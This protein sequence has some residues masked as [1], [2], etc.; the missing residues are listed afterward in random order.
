MTSSTAGSTTGAQRGRA[1]PGD[2]P[3]R[4]VGARPVLGLVVLGLVALGL[5]VLGTGVVPT[6]HAQATGGD[7]YRIGDAQP[8]DSVNPFNEQNEISF[9]ITSLTYDLLLNYGTDDAQPDLAHSLARSYHVSKDGKTWRFILR[10]GVTWSDGKPFTSADVKWT[11]DAVR[12]NTTNV[13][14]AYLANVSSVRAPTTTSVVLKLSSPDVRISSIFVPILPKHVFAK[15]PVKKLDSISLPLPSVTTAPF[16][17]TSYDKTGTTILTRNPRFRGAAPAMRRVLVTHYGNEDSL[18]R[19]LK[20]GALDMVVDG[21]TRWASTLKSD[22][23][24]EQWSGASPGFSE[25]AFNSCPP[26]G[27]RVACTGAG[28]NVRT[29][30]S[31]TPAIR[32][33]LYYAINRPESARKTRAPEPGHRRQRPDLAVLQ[34]ATTRTG[35]PGPG[36]GL[37]VR[38]GQGRSSPRRPGAGTAPPAASAPRT[39]RRPSSVLSAQ[40]NDEPGQNAMRRVEARAGEIGMKIKSIVT[41]EQNNKIYAPTDGNKYEP[42]STPSTGAGAATTTPDFDLSVL[43]T[44]QRVAGLDATA[45]RRTT[46]SSPRRPEGARLRQAPDAAARCG[47]DR[48]DRRALPDHRPRQRRTR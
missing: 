21:N 48:A 16:Q 24:I 5:V 35:R 30:S 18:L 26:G 31:R 9:A 8:V 40:T 2:R 33:A 10:S 42:T 6:P 44:R 11:Y 27:G 4:R 14:N 38:P 29:R 7:D 23:D 25:I 13:M 22:E 34:P 28:K 46:S 41:E 45:T 37:R 17:I 15:Y 32:H 12:H 19:D 3:T 43:E 20:L 1:R 36:D 47:E 39:G